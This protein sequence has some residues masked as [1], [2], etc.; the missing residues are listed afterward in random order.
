MAQQKVSDTL[1]EALDIIINK[2]IE[3]VQKDKTI[4][5]VVEDN[6]KAEEG[7][8]IVSNASAKFTA[9]SEN[10]AYRNG[11]N[12]WVLIP[13]GDYNNEKKIIGKHMGDSSTPYV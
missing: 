9:Y 11:Q 1:F 10:T 2:R 6:S 4:L 3:A 8:Y 5:C 13:E 12:V 7:E